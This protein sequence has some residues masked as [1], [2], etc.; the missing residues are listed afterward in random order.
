M[1]LLWLERGLPAGA[2]G[3]FYKDDPVWDPIRND[4][5]FPDLLRQMAFRSKQRITKE[6]LWIT[7]H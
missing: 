3:A 6:A 1:A 5:R 2:I 4:P 7:A